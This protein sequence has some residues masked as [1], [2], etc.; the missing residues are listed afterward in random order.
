MVD[1][2]CG[3]LYGDKGYIS[4]PLERELLNKEVTLIMGVKKHEIKLDETLEPLD[5]P[6]TICY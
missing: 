1:E 4:A 3:C 5:A 2:L 6:E